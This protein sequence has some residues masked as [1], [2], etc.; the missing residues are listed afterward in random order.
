M[1]FS[2]YGVVST[3][4]L[5]RCRSAWHWLAT[6]E[7]VLYGETTNWCCT[8]R[9]WNVLGEEIRLNTSSWARAIRATAQSAS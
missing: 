5:A 6:E 3:H 9:K 8:Y 7:T 4:A 1:P 2:T